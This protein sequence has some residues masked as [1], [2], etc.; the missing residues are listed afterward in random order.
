MA[1]NANQWESAPNLPDD[2]FVSAETYTDETIL[3][4][5]RERIFH[6]C[7][8]FACHESELPNSGDY[9]TLDHAGVPI[10][11][12]R[13]EEGQVRA[14]I[15]SCSHRGSLIATELRGN[16]KRLT[17]F[18]HLWSY[19]QNGDCTHI[20][21]PEGYQRC[22]VTTDKMGLRAVRVACRL[23]MVFINLDDSAENFDDFVGDALQDLDAPM[24]TVDLE[25]FH[26]H[27]VTMRA[28]WKQWHETNMELYHEWGH[29][30]NR[31]TS[32]AVPG[33]HERK[34]KI[35]PNGHGSLD[36]LRV[37]Y[38]N[39]RG[40]DSRDS[41]ILPG[42]APAEFRVVDLFPNTTVIVRGTVI[43]IDTTIPV[44]PGLTIL[45]QRGLGVKGERPED[46]RVRQLHHNQ[47]WGPF[48]RNLSEDVIFVEAVEQANRRGGA[49]HGIIARHENLMSQ[50]DEIM[51]AYYRVWSRHMGRSA[52]DPH[53]VLSKPRSKMAAA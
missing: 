40:W 10:V 38:D 46:R 26:L 41:L 42:L 35:H 3:N 52:S 53:G 2:H 28:N 48:G 43:R 37:R 49:R 4:E 6:K 30:V 44:A 27:R 20:T 24:G 12:I 11:I 14:F 34:W 33:Y 19:D 23:G 32:V 51:R 17:C 1:R 25:V 39:Y 9:R 16:A 7:W 31:T 47:F 45:E 29:V 13:G 21:R 22:G 5:E 15:N 50:D 18:F 8:K 36:P